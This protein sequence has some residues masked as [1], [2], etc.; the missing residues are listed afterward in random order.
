MA[1][2]DVESPSRK[3]MFPTTAIFILFVNSFIV[4]KVVT[5][6]QHS[7]DAQVVIQT[8]YLIFS[9]CFRQTYFDF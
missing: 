8:L 2:A 5:V 9:E 6:S 1:T 7:N 4:Y 3:D